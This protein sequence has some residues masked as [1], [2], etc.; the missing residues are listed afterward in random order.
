MFFEEFGV[1]KQCAENGKVFIW[2]KYMRIAYIYKTT[3]ISNEQCCC[4]CCC[5]IHYTACFNVYVEQCSRHMYFF[6]ILYTTQYNTIQ[7]NGTLNVVYVDACVCVCIK[8]M[9]IHYYE[10]SS[11][12]VSSV[13]A[14][15][16]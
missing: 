14:P 1:E 15:L 13:F 10:T 16:T 6:I 2:L 5:L 3:T 8:S 4:C 9:C 7:Y 11:I 12:N